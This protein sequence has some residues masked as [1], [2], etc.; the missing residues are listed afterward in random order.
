M[1]KLWRLVCLNLRGMLNSLKMGSGKKKGAKVTGY[2]ALLLLG[3]L[4]VYI[5]GVYSF[6]FASLLNEVGLIQYLT[7]M[8]AILGCALS[9]VLTIQAASGFIF[10]GKDSDLMLSL[11]VSAFSVML[12]RITALYIENLFFIGLFMVTSGVAAMVQ[13][14]GGVG[15]MVGLLICTLLLSFLTTMITT[16]LSFGVSWLAAH[17]PHHKLFSTVLY[18]A[19]FILIMVGAFQ[20]NN[21]GTLLLA[22][23]EA[24]DRV[25]GSWLLPFGLV[26]KGVSG[27]VGAILLLAAIAV[28]PF[29]LIVWLFSSQYKKVLSALAARSVRNDYKL[30]NLRASGQFQSLFRREVKRYFG[31][32]IYFFN[33]GFGAVVLIV[34]AV[35][36]CFVHRQVAEYVEVFSQM[37]GGMDV[38]TALA[39]LAIGFFSTTICT[40]CVSIS[41]EGKTFWILKEAP[42]PSKTYFASKIAVNL[43]VAW[44]A[45]LICAL[46]LGIVYGVN[47]VTLA[48]AVFVLL[49][50]GLLVAVYGL[51]I[52]LFF[53]KM[54]AVNDTV[55]V[56]QSASA[57]IGALGGWLILGIAVGGYFLFG[58]LMPMAGYMAVLGALFLVLSG[59]IW[60]W[61]LKGGT[62]KL[63]Q[64][65]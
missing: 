40:T 4:A 59:A 42:V 29:L 2:G 19:M 58:K 5:S 28:I 33:T 60:G 32:T 13:G 10:S 48:A 44:P 45:P 12:S 64:L 52:N 27:D 56:K 6:M 43:L 34:A 22:N 18:F 8:M 55:V 23:R 15:Y 61:L 24:F 26:M 50:L 53:P 37:V 63:Q 39:V 38:L 30:G 11:P 17:F 9:L 47:P 49:A 41:L 46:S 25:L 54:D 20:L 14:A 16:V 51:A 57:L 1:G 65:D 7:P 35:Y 36:G 21:V 31:T 3:F 62:R